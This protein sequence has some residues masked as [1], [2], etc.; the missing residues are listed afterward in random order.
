MTQTLSPHMMQHADGTIACLLHAPSAAR[1]AALRTHQ[2]WAKRQAA[3]LCLEALGYDAPAPLPHRLGEASL[4][5]DGIY[6]S[7]SASGNWAYAALHRHKQIGID[8][9]SL[10]NATMAPEIT[11]HAMS[12]QDQRWIKEPH[13]ALRLWSAKE[14]V[15]KLYAG[16]VSFEEVTILQ[17]ATARRSIA[18]VDHS[19]FVIEHRTS[20]TVLRSWA[21]M[22]L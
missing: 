18:C 10:K 17:A 16:A 8:V 1:G 4:F 13:D 7:L 20:G 22:A 2:H 5:P 3:Q 15:I 11:A 9:E 6:G 21:L 14:C 19:Q 12:P